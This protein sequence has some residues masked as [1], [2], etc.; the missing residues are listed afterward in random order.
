MS[1]RRLTPTSVRAL[2]ISLLVLPPVAVA[3]DSR[4]S[5][6]PWLGATLGGD[7]RIHRRAR[8][9]PKGYNHRRN[10]NWLPPCG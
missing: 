1:G 2:C 4:P 7:Y 6:D 9:R 8:R 5:I 10:H 3:G